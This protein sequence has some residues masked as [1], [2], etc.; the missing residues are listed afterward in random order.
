MAKLV[1]SVKVTKAITNK[2]TASNKAQQQIE[3]VS[4]SSISKTL[5][6]REAYQVSIYVR[7]AVSAIAINVAKAKRRLFSRKTGEEIVSGEAYNFIQ[8]QITPSFVEKMVSWFQLEGEMAVLKGIDGVKLKKLHILD[9]AFLRF[10]PQNTKNLQD[11][12]TW[13]YTDG[14]SV[15]N[16]V[17][18]EIPKDLVIWASNFNPSHP[19][20]GISPAIS[21]AQEITSIYMANRYNSSYF[22]NGGN[23]SVIVRFPEGTPEKTASEWIKKWTMQ[24]G[25]YYQNGFKVGAVIGKDM[26]IQELG[27]T[28]KDGDFSKLTQTNAEAI[29]GLWGVPPSV[30]GFLSRTRFDTINVELESF[31]ENTLLPQIEIINDFIQKGLIDQHF[32]ISL[33]S[34]KE[35]TSLGK[36]AKGLWEKAKSET[37]SDVVFMLDPDTLPI[38]AKLKIAQLET[39]NK[40]RLSTASSFK[41]AAEWAGIDRKNNAADNLITLPTSEKPIEAQKEEKVI[42]ETPKEVDKDALKQLKDFYTEY[43]SLV[44]SST[45]KNKAYTLQSTKD[46]AIKHKVYDYVKVAIA[47]DL[48]AIKA[49][50]DK[51]DPM[52]DVKNYLNE[53]SKNSTLKG[54]LCE[55]S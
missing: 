9:P 33:A 4:A 32:A 24:H 17:V 35:G 43:R 15:G 7:K 49:M 12:T 54:L 5:S 21:G 14:Q 10:N 34:K 23:L 31:F 29:G 25:F 40:Y 39:M 22:E 47:K 18:M 16:S 13:T 38:A 30:M 8:E 20:R 51:E 41:D 2:N 48:L 3:T 36:Y 37:Q 55:N 26:E 53:V 28:P 50:Q 11:I 44:L 27:K 6:P 1:K 42:E 46:L 45:A 52:P 19:I